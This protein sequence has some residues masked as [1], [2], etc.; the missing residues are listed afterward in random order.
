MGGIWWW[1]RT[2]SSTENSHRNVWIVRQPLSKDGLSDQDEWR[3]IHHHTGSNPGFDK[4]IDI[5]K[6]CMPAMVSYCEKIATAVGAPFLRA[7]FFVGSPKWG[8]RLNEVAYGCGCDYRNCEPQ[9]PTR[10]FDDAP[11]MAQILQEGMALCQNRLP[12]RT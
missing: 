11:A 5:F 1:G 2:K 10:I 9:D 8:V 3:V 12:P 4:A 7:D 6:R